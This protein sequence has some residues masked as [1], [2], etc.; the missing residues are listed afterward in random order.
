MS[1][2]NDLI[3]DRKNLSGIFTG[4][5]GDRIPPHGTTHVKNGP[6][7][8]PQQLDGYPVDLDGMSTGETIVLDA[9]GNLVPGAALGALV[10][11]QTA[12]DNGGD[13]ALSSDDLNITVSESYDFKIRDAGSN[14][15]FD[16]SDPASVSTILMSADVLR[17]KDGNL[18][19]A[20]PLSSVGNVSLNTTDGSIVGAIN[21]VLSGRATSL[22]ELNAQL[23]GTTIDE[24]TDTRDPSAHAIGGSAHTASTL[25][26]LNTKI[27]D[28]D[29]GDAVSSQ[30]LNIAVDNVSGLLLQPLDISGAKITGVNEAAFATDP[31]PLHQVRREG[32]YSNVVEDIVTSP[33]TSDPG[34]YWLVGSGATGDF[35]GHDN[36][37]VH[38]AVLKTTPSAMSDISGYTT[39]TR[40]ALYCPE[41]DTVLAFGIASDDVERKQGDGDFETLSN[42]LSSSSTWQNSAWSG[43]RKVAVVSTNNAS[44]SAIEMSFDGGATWI[45]CTTPAYA[46]D[47]LAVGGVNGDVFV[48]T[49]RTGSGNNRILRNRPQDGTT[50]TEVTTIP[51]MGDSLYQA[52]WSAVDQKFAVVGLF[53]GGFFLSDENGENWT[54]PN[55]S[56]PGTS[57]I[58]CVPWLEK[59]FTARAGSAYLTSDGTTTES[60][61]VPNA[62]TWAFATV[63]L[64]HKLIVWCSSAGSNDPFA[65]SE[66]GETGT[67]TTISDGDQSVWRGLL[68]Y[69]GRL[70]A[71]SQDGTNRAMISDVDTVWE[72]TPLAD[73]QKI[74][75]RDSD[76]PYRYDGASLVA[77]GELTE[78]QKTDLT[79]GGT[80]TL[81]T[82]VATR[83]TTSTN[84]SVATTDRNNIITVLDTRT[85]NVVINID[86]AVRAI[87]GFTFT[88]VVE[89]DA[90]YNADLNIE[91]PSS[92]Y[93]R[94][95]GTSS[96][97]GYSQS[98]RY[99]IDED[100]NAAPVVA[101]TFHQD[102]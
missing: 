95:N 102:A 36:E 21:E 25:A 35:A 89:Y 61:T 79:D 87:P 14:I 16:V 82:H 34:K 26:E 47:G 73:G 12:Y 67:W 20:V 97:G 74:Y 32:R 23:G 17:L 52:C 72:F 48:A 46:I 84:T 101:P 5:G 90:T 71:F 63:L 51:A 92:N 27:S 80:T 75:D 93:W 11:L 55:A 88:I 100:G 85:A 81:H 49:I 6:D 2:I 42:V 66:T 69:H 83:R 53:T 28:A 19:A 9:D 56:Y 64:S 8:I 96:G 86:S 24:S 10:S 70:L 15:L 43:A 91:A 65:L 60:V 68:D 58:V 39:A 4:A 29:L 99:Y 44:T 38:D 1:D 76:T 54:Q 22:S 41:I 7:P 3:Q 13:I 40:T 31:T 30:D 59:Y 37:V 45:A 57:S 78:T 33:P 94:M 98:Y 62:N 77:L 18:S 50:W